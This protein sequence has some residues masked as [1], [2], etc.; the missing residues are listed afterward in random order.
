M[1]MSLNMKKI[2]LVIAASYGLLSAFGAQATVIDDAAAGANSYWGA[3]AHGYGDV[4]GD[5]P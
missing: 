3:D 2:I 5:T 4:I 1:E